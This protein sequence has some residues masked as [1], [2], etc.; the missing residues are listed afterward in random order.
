MKTWASNSIDNIDPKIDLQIV[1]YT[2]EICLFFFWQDMGI[3]SYKLENKLNKVLR[4]LTYMQLFYNNQ[5]TFCMTFSI[6][7][8]HISIN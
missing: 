5:K 4:L 6:N 3:C 7:S 1:T 8:K 2:N